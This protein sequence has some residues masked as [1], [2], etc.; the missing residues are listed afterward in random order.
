MQVEPL[1]S[2]ETVAMGG[3]RLE[4]T[5]QVGGVA[6]HTRSDASVQF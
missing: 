4:G 3:E 5:G 2:V 1:G 6:F